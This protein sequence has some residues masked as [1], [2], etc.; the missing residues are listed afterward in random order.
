MNSKLINPPF[1]KIII[2]VDFKCLN[3]INLNI[4]RNNLLLLPLHNNILENM[5]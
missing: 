2:K 1:M 3:I 4:Y 5:N